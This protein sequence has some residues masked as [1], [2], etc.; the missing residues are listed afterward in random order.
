MARLKHHKP[1]AI[2]L[3]LGHQ[4]L[5]AGLLAKCWAHPGICLVRGDV[6]LSICIS[7]KFLCAV[8]PRTPICEET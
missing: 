4:T 3:I 8:S 2:V 7:N 5:L 6:G 1:K